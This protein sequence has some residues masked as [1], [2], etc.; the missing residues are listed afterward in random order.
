MSTERPSAAIGPANRLPSIYEWYIAYFSTMLQ[1]SAPLAQYF[2][3]P[4]VRLLAGNRDRRAP[5]NVSIPATEYQDSD[6]P[7]ASLQLTGVRKQEESSCEY[8]ML[9]EA[10]WIFQTVSIDLEYVTRAAECVVYQHSL[11]W[12]MQNLLPSSV[13]RLGCADMNTS[14]M[15]FELDVIGAKTLCTSSVVQVSMLFPWTPTYLDRSV[16]LKRPV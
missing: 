8:G 2:K 6:F 7:L 11:R 3:M 10:R 12:Y 4:N 5:W 9:M 14:D 15:T 13:G 16:E 1:P